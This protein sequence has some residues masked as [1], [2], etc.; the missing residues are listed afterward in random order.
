MYDNIQTSLILVCKNVI[1]IIT[2]D[3]PIEQMDL[4]ERKTVSDP[5]GRELV[6]VMKQGLSLDRYLWCRQELPDMS[7][8]QAVRL[9]RLKNLHLGAYKRAL[10]QGYSK[11]T[12]RYALVRGVYLRDFIKIMT[13]TT[14]TPKAAVEVCLFHNG[15]CLQ[16]YIVLRKL[17]L[18]H[19]KAMEIMKS[20]GEWIHLGVLDYVSLR[21]DGH[22]DREARR[23]MRGDSPVHTFK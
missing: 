5:T 16:D 9:L 4:L 2:V 19:A 17:N 1:N 10:E 15:V 21:K 23:L 20:C 11:R 14:A 22:N 8:V 13:N 3:H 12:L 7:H 18:S 6:S